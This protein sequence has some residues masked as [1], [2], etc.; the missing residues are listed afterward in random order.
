MG[1]PVS[2]RLI[3]AR[4]WWSMSFGFRPILTPFA[5][6]RSSSPPICRQGTE[7]GSG[8]RNRVERVQQIVCRARQPVETCHHQHV[9]FGK[10]VEW[11]G[12]Y[13]GAAAQTAKS[14]FPERGRPVLDTTKLSRVM[15]LPK[16][17]ECGNFS[18]DEVIIPGRYRF[19][20]NG[21]YLRKSIEQSNEPASPDDA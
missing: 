11:S 12:A 16:S 10:Q 14:A 4:L 21:D 6:A 20:F 7:S 2:R 8:L 1:S 5:L 9:A 19:K 17:V 15:A 18:L 3:A 13:K